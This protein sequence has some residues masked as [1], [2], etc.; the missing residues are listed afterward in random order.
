LIGIASISIPFQLITLVGLNIFLALGR[1][2]GFNLFDLAGQSFVLVNAIVALILLNAGLWLLVSLNTGASIVIALLIASLIVAYGAKMK[3]RAAW[4]PSLKLFGR[5]MRYG[6]KFH[7]ATLA[8]LLIFRIDLLFVNRFRGAAEAGVYSVASQVGMMLMLLPGVIATLL[9]PRIT[10]DKETRVETTCRA[11]RHTTFIMLLICLASVPASF[12][13]P[14]LYGASFRDATVQLLILLPGVFLIGIESVLVQYFS[15]TGL[16]VAIPLFWLLTL[17]INLALIFALV[18]SFGARGAAIASTICYALIFALI[19][20]YFRA[21][22][23]NK[24]SNAL[25]LR[26][27]ELRSLLK[28][29]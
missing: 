22:T 7:I 19:A 17:V 28:M 15:A 3:E 29:A 8:G 12:V 2:A 18:P 13:L 9:F 26:P 24:I 1:V 20:F 21:Q 16:P 25:V 11:T 4:C 5:M 27:R 10:A 14:L 6:I 23:G